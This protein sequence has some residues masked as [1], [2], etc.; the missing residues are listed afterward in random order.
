M[1]KC[2]KI[3]LFTLVAATSALA[4]GNKDTQKVKQPR[5]PNVVKEQVT[6]LNEEYSFMIQR[7]DPT[8]IAR[9]L[10]DDYIL[11]DE[12]GKVFTKADDLASYKNR[13]IKIDSV[14]T[15]NQ[16]VRIVGDAVV[17]ANA[18]INFQGSKNGKAFDLT[19]Q[20]TTI[21]AW[22]GGRWQVVSDHISFVKQ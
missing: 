5:D 12:N 20:C 2:L 17:I 15:L 4:Q 21:W 19:E 16:K 13:Q 8:E 14:K 22:R 18:T 3:L 7:G 10:A 9:V 1:K 6:R 11:T